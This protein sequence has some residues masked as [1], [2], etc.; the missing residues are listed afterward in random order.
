MKKLLKVIGCVIGGIVG[1][2]IL[3]VVIVAVT[4]K[5]KE[6]ATTENAQVQEAAAR[7]ISVD[8]PADTPTISSTAS[9]KQD[10]VITS[11]PRPTS[12]ATPEPSAAETPIQTTSAVSARIPTDTPQSTPVIFQYND[13]I[14]TFFNSYNHVN[15]EHMVRRSQ[16]SP[17]RHHGG[18]HFDQAISTVDGFEVVVSETPGNKIK[19]YIEGYKQNKS[20]DEYKSLFSSFARAYDP[21]LD[22]EAIDEYWSQILNADSGYS[23]GFIDFNA[24]EYSHTSYS[25]KIEY[26]VLEGPFSGDSFMT[27]GINDDTYDAEMVGSRSIE[28]TPAPTTNAPRHTIS[29]SGSIA[30]VTNT[31]VVT[32]SPTPSITRTLRPTAT[33]TPKPTATRRP[34]P[35]PTPKPTAT[36]RPTPTPTPRPTATPRRTATP[37]PAATARR[38]NTPAP[39]PVTNH[40]VLNTNTKKFHRPTCSSVSRMSSRNRRD[41]Y[42]TYED[43]IRRGYEPCQRCNP[44]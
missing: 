44:R 1:L 5:P 29:T 24:F 12:H 32:A 37:R 26:A 18:V 16:Y 39:Q 25:G 33:P 14:N 13:R 35:T 21:S 43:M 4:D 42:C 28:E 19:V 23:T 11:T 2:F 36:R 30:R 6:T 22:A 7:S 31:P 15:P 10:D 20:N 41:E 38:T 8:M 17:Y 9:E 27:L 34:T 3:L 40:Y